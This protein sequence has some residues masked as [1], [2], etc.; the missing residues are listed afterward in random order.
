MSAMDDH[1]R[2]CAACCDCVGDPD[3][4]PHPSPPELQVADVLRRARRLPVGADRGDLRQLAAGLLSLR[5]YG[6]EA[7]VRRAMTPET[8]GRGSDDRPRSS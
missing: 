5:R 3:M 2:G 4:Q 6:I 1:H 8:M 7:L